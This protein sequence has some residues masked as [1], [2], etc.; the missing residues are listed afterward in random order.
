M[1]MT[2]TIRGKGIV[3]VMDSAFCLMDAVVALRNEGIYT[4]TVAKKRAYWPRNI[5]GDDVLAHMAGKPVGELHGRRG[6]LNGVPFHIFA[7]SHRRYTFILVATHGSTRVDTE[8]RKLRTADGHVLFFRRNEPI[9]DYYRARHAVDDH[10]HYRQGQRVSLEAAWGSKFWPN[11][12]LGFV[13]CVVL[14]NAMM[15]HN[16]FV[17]PRSGQDKL[18][19]DDFKYIVARELVCKWEE[20]AKPPGAAA[21]RPRRAAVVEH[22]HLK[23]SKYEGAKPGSRTACPYQQVRCRGTGCSKSI[24]TYCSC[25]RMLFLCSSC[26]LEHFS[27]VSGSQ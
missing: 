25:N 1:R 19:F 16:H 6:K 10:N 11:R 22:R 4:A 26:F 3:V 12:Q 17:V 24:R 21:N 5:P 2:E 7:V 9:N 23:L 18:S 8:P 14:V 13:L 15:A 20:R 27:D